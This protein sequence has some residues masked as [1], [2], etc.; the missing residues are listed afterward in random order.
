[1]GPSIKMSLYTYKS[2]SGQKFTYSHHEDECHGNLGRL[3]ISLRCSL[4]QGRMIAQHASLITLKKQ[5]L[6][7]QV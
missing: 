6:G 1:M 4:F 3:I 5:K 7:A 2:S